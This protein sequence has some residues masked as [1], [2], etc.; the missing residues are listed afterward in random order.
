MRV[1]RD[2][3]L[4][5]RTHNLSE[6]DR[7]ITALTKEN[8]KVRAVA[9]GVRRTSSKIGSR[10]EPF[11]GFDAQLYRGKNLDTFTQVVST[12]SYG[13]AISADYE[14]FTVGT[15]MLELADQIVTEEGEP[16]V[17]QYLLLHGALHALAHRLHI[18][19]LIFDSYQLRALAI[20][21][22]AVSPYDCA[23]CG[24]AGPHS[25][26][27]VSQGGAVCSV[28]RP[29]GSVSAGPAT[30]ELLAALLAGQWE[31]A[32]AAEA[33]NR[34]EVSGMVAAFAQFHLERSLRSLPMI[35][36]STK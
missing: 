8:G 23:H 12:S 26:F 31:I 33:R 25:S 7:I 9:R 20:A 3:G 16:A 27:S 11:M 35:E 17:Q 15:A 36:R 21:G 4:V 5:L 10:L 14:L 24:T 30:F 2:E 1:Y 13:S 29:P 18:P 19:E 28:C 34:R 22:W 6:A 32:D